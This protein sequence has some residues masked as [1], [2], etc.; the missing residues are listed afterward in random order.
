[1]NKNELISSIAER[2]GLSKAKAAEAIDAFVT[3]IINTL[4][5]GGDIRIPGFGTF[6]ILHRKATK[7]RNPLT[8]AE[9]QIPSRKVPKFSAG[10]LMKE[11]VNRK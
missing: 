10:K 3:S 5:E 4:S 1:M 9:I 2:A 11:S 6:E 7:G 8:G